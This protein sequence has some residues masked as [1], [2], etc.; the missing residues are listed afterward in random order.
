MRRP[1]GCGGAAAGGRLPDVICGDKPTAL[2]GRV[3]KQSLWS[4]MPLVGSWCVFFEF[5]FFSRCPMGPH[6]HISMGPNVHMATCTHVHVSMGPRAH[7]AT[8]AHVHLLWVRMYTCP[9]VPM[10]TWP[11]VE[12]AHL[13]GSQGTRDVRAFV[14]VC[15]GAFLRVCERA[16]VRARACAC[17]R[18]RVR[19][20]VCVP[21]QLCF[22]GALD[23]CVCV[24]LRA[25]WGR[26]V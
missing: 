8:R 21:A 10:C 1:D 26:D 25:P 9:W 6:V 24:C 3:K 17:V 14:R 7:M 13:H 23:A 2:V 11:H 16:V 19:L 20:R 22:P 18:R 15:V 12:C 5:C 4:D